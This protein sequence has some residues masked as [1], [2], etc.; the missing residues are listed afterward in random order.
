M[1]LDQEKMTLKVKDA[2]MQAVEKS[3]AERYSEVCWEQWAL[4]LSLQKDS[5]WIA[6]LEPELNDLKT[7]LQSIIKSKPRL[8]HHSEQIR[9]SNP[10]ENVFSSAQKFKNSMGDEFLST[11]HF[12]LASFEEDKIIGTILRKKFKTQDELKEAIMNQRGGNS[13]DNDQPENS[14]NVLNKYCK[15]LTED[16]RNGQLDPVIGRDTEIRRVVQVLSR[17]TKNNPVLI[18]EPGVGKTAIAEGLALRIV[19]GDVPEGLKDKMLL[20]LDMGLLVAGAKYR[21]EFEERLKNIIKD[22]G[23]SN[24]KIILFIDELHTLVG[25][26][27][28]DGAMDA[29]QLLKPALARGELRCIG[30]TTLE[31]Y[32]KYIEKDKALERR[33]Q[34]TLVEEPSVED[35]IT[36]LR[37]IKDKYETHHG[38]KIMDSALIAAAELSDR[39]I[40]SRFLPDKAI[41]LIDEAASQLHIE[42]H[43]V[44]K[45]LDEINR[46][47]TR[48]SVELKALENE[49]KN[50]NTMDSQ[51]AK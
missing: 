37:G 35:T 12:L 11:E 47:V 28:T 32:K 13:T 24:G 41:D 14:M 42:I 49:Q 40:S 18:G 31:E 8:T 10:L 25:A 46:K 6:F 43:S 5:L 17:R 51:G 19:N 7:Q 23:K 22:I 34:S 33:F 1:K 20:S 30:A 26:G 9:F 16:A 44:P 36:I 4:E 15:N 50:M 29:G 3:I 48:L 45:V 2:L 39:Y 27:K 21:G 38:V